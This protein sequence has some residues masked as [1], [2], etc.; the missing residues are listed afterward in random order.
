MS[1]RCSLQE[2]P[3]VME[4]I[5]QGSQASSNLVNAIMVSFDNPSLDR[6]L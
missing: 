5:V 2:K 6:W 4:S 3:K 1:L